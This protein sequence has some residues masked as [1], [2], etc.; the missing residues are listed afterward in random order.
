METL[1]GTASRGAGQVRGGGPPRRALECDRRAGRGRGAR[2]GSAI[3]GR[4]ARGCG[5][6]DRRAGRDDEG[7][8]RSRAGGG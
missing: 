8:G 5:A 2:P 7:A 6:G 1:M 3:A 4:G